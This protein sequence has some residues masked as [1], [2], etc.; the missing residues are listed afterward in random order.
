VEGDFYT[1]GESA[2]LLGLTPGRIRQMLQSGEM[3]GTKYPMS[4]RWRIP[5]H[6]VHARLEERRPREP[7]ESSLPASAL[8]DRLESLA[9]ELGRVE[10]EFRAQKEL[11]EVT[12]ST[13]REQLQ[14]EQER[15]D[16]LEAALEAER[17]RG[18]WSRL[19]GG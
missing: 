16:R 7:R 12:E 11:S 19:F 10:G 5:Q 6:V 3:E 13:L 9:R 8:Q 2:R 17:S 15:A 4:D 18:F 14:R 1:V